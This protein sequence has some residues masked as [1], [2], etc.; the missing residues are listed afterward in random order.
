MTDLGPTTEARFATAFA[1]TAIVTAKAAAELIGLDVKTLDALA[2]KQ[3]IRSV[4]KGKLRAYTERDLRAY[5]IE[6]PDAACPSTSRPK[7]SSGSSTLSSV[8]VGFTAL[9]AKRHD[10]Q[11]KPSRGSSGSTRQRAG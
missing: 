9:Q 2:E 11:R 8:V 4:P 7:A 5:L 6:G 3:V 10:A 1:R